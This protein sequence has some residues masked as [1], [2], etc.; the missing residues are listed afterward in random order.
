MVDKKLSG[1]VKGREQGKINPPKDKLPVTY[2]LYPDP[3]FHCYT[4]I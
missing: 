1:T 4:K 3:T 2:F